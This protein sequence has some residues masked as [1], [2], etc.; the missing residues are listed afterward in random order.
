MHD[1]Y[2]NAGKHCLKVLNKRVCA[3]KDSKHMI[4]K[5][6]GKEQRENQCRFAL[7]TIPAMRRVPRAAA[8]PAI[9]R[10]M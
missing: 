1:A 3:R 8:P 4:K 5:V 6:R 7:R 2:N 9:A 10:P